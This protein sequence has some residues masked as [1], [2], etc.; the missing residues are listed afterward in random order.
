MPGLR[1][2][3]ALGLLM[4]GLTPAIARGPSCGASCAT[5]VFP[6]IAAAGAVCLFLAVAHYLAVAF[7]PRLRSWADARRGRAKNAVA[8]IT[9]ALAGVGALT[10]IVRM[11][12]RL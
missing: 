12:V 3:A 1:A 2:T 5:W 11:Y 7:A 9:L 4:A 8:G 10:F 6:L